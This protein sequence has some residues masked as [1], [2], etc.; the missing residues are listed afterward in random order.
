[1]AANLSNEKEVLA[2]LSFFIGTIF[3]SIDSATVPDSNTIQQWYP[4]WRTRQ[5]KFLTAMMAGPVAVIR[6]WNTTLRIPFNSIT[7]FRL[8]DRSD[9]M[10]IILNWGSV[11]E[12]LWY[13]S[14]H[15]HLQ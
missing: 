1:M 2:F 12:I 3:S 9:K 4:V 7:P 13:C 5:Q 15:P 14:Q 10:S 8:Q 11:S 6:D